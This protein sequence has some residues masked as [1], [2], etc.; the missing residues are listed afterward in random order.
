MLLLGLEIT[1]SIF[2]VHVQIVLPHVLLVVEGQTLFAATAM[3]SNVKYVI[4]SIRE[5]P[6]ARALPQGLHQELEFHESAH[7]LLFDWTHLTSLIVNV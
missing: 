7:L 1:R 2:A 3:T 4:T 5:R 6:V